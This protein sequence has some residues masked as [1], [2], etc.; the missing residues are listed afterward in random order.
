VESWSKLFLLLG[1]RTREEEEESKGEG[2]AGFIS[3]LNHKGSEGRM[4]CS[5]CRPGMKMLEGA[6]KARSFGANP[7]PELSNPTA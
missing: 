2:C 5:G 4:S 1:L 7:S 6:R 3:L